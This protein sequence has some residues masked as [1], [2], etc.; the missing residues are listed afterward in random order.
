MTVEPTREEGKE[1]SEERRGDDGD[2]DGRG[3][4]SERERVTERGP[5]SL[6]G[7]R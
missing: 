6:P 5:L 1:D 7:L 4:T 2:G 3:D